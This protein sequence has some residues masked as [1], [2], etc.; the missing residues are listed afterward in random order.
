MWGGS[1]KRKGERAG[2]GFMFAHSQ[3]QRTELYRSQEQARAKQTR[4]AKNNA[5]NKKLI[6]CYNKRFLC[7][8]FAWYKSMFVKCH[9]N[10]KIFLFFSSSLTATPLRWWSI[11]PVLFVFYHP[12]ATDFE[13]KMEG[14][15]TGYHGIFNSGALSR[16]KSARSGAPW[17][18]KFGKLSIRENLVMT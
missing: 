5:S 13:E 18:R 10:S 9:P 7:S 11:N 8:C 1:G 14:L 12:R 15:W 2:S 3:S 17:V 6:G 4:S 16:A